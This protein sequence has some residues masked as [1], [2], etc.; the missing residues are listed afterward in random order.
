MV[1]LSTLQSNQCP[2][3]LCL[4]YQGN[5]LGRYPAFAAEEV[6]TPPILTVAAS[7]MSPAVKY[8]SEVK[9]CK[10]L[11]AL[12]RR[13]F[14]ASKKA[15]EAAALETEVFCLHIGH[16]QYKQ[17]SPTLLSPLE[18]PPVKDPFPTPIL[19]VCLLCL[20]S[21]DSPFLTHTTAFSFLG[22]ASLCKSCLRY[23]SWDR[24][25]SCQILI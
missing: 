3:P 5:P 22:F 17:A 2:S 11:I 23:H 14:Q 25:L 4:P 13:E 7:E 15:A 21:T 16:V 20:H 19:C 1:V 18:G 6:T 10:V 12:K 24:S 8:S 9:P